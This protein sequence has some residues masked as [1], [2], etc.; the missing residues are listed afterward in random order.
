MQPLDGLQWLA[1]ALSVLGAPLTAMR[2]WY[3]W[4]IWLLA[5][6]AF[7]PIFIHS[8]LWGTVALY[9]YFTFTSALGLYKAVRSE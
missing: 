7:L 8:H 9:V 5:D 4:L 6:L 1:V 3:G 2:K